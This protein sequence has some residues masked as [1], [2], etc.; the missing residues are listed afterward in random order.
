LQNTLAWHAVG[1]VSSHKEQ[2][3]ARKKLRETHQAEVQRPVRDLVYLPSDRDRLHFGRGGAEQASAQI[4]AEI[5][6][7]ESG[8]GGRLA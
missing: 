5:C 4:M 8:A 7:V 1:D 2:T 6:I 3:N